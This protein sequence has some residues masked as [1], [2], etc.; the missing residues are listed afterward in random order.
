MSVN[1]ATQLVDQNEAL[2]LQLEGIA[3]RDPRK[4]FALYQWEITKMQNQLTNNNP[5]LTAAMHKIE[6][7]M[8]RNVHRMHEFHMTEDNVPTPVIPQVSFNDRQA[9]PHRTFGGHFLTYAEIGKA[10]KTSKEWKLIAKSD[11]KN[12]MTGNVRNF[13]LIESPS[14]Q[15]FAV[16]WDIV[17]F[18]D[19]KRR[20]IPGSVTH[21]I[22]IMKGGKPVRINPFAGN[23]GWTTRKFFDLF[24]NASAG[25]PYFAYRAPHQIALIALLLD[26]QKLNIVEKKDVKRALRK[27]AEFSR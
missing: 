21:Y 25:S 22:F 26:G 23:L 5:D 20:V 8:L 6:A 27:I 4:S 3:D 13:I 12:F 24:P 19:E 15:R 1:R 16:C 7:E 10:I 2:K 18:K 9:T 14:K 17:A 11:R